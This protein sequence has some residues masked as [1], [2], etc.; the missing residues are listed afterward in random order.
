MK[1][2]W[3][4]PREELVR[5][6]ERIYRYRMTTTS[7]GNLS[8]RDD[9]GD[10]WITPSR[11]DKGNLRECDIACVH[12]DGRRT[13]A[14]APSSEFPFHRQIYETRPDIRAIVHA[15]SVALVAFSMT[16]EAPDTR[17]LPQ[18][19]EVCG[20]VICAPYA[21]PGSDALAGKIAE[22]FAGGAHCVLLENHGVVTGG[23]DLQEAFQRFETLEFAAQ[24]ILKASALSTVRFL[25]ETQLG[26]PARALTPLPEAAPPVPTSREKE[27]RWQLCR[28][29]HRGYQ[30]RLLISTAG[31]FS[32]RLDADA[33]LITPFHRDRLEL[34]PEDI[35]LVHNGNAERGKQASRA[36]RLHRSIYRRHPEVMAI[37]NATPVHA[38]AFGVCGQTLDSRTIPESFIILGDIRRVPFAQLYE[39]PESLS[40]VLSLN[41]PVAIIENGGVL[42]LGRSVLD[43]FDRLEVLEATAETTIAG[44]Q[45]G[46]LKPMP[47]HA[48]NELRA[49]FR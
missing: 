1:H 18:A 5:T 49:A 46:P 6:M 7:G 39:Q 26:L 8:I 30:Q 35:V 31:S 19:R 20:E 10:I 14:A 21:L 16:G 43:A 38:T 33:F 15:H 25:D 42:V 34:E 22:T 45:L 48:I 40:G 13:G 2:R 37:I 3:L 32:A 44:R 11:L 29:V 28:F 12:P 27:L 36:A 24:T 17:L 9:T 47:E 4:H 23:A 41:A